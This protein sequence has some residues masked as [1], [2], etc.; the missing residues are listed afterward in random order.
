MDTI[1]PSPFAWAEFDADGGL[2]DAGAAAA[3]EAML[4]AAGIAD[5]VVLSHGW[6]NSKADAMT[7]YRTLWGNV[8]SALQRKN[9]VHIAV[10][11]VVWPSKAFSTDFDDAAAVASAAG[12]TL[13]VGDGGGSGDLDDARFEAAIRGV[14]ELFGPDS[15]PIVAAARAAAQGID[16]NTAS[17]FFE[18]AS[19]AVTPLPGDPELQQNATMFTPDARGVSPEAALGRL[20]PP[21][22]MSAAPGLGHASG[23]VDTLGAIFS[24][25]RAAVARAL[26]VLTYYEMKTR[27]GIVGAALGGRVLPGLHVSAGKSLHLVGHSFGARLVTAAAS[28]L[29]AHAPFAFSSLTLLQGA[30]SHN[31]LSAQASGA[32]ANVIGRPSGPIAITH[33][34]NDHACTYWYALASRLS[35]DSTQGFGDAD[36]IFGAMGANGAQKLPPGAIVHDTTGQTFAPHRGKVNG[37]LADGYVVEVAGVTDAH[38]NVANPTCGKLVAAVLEA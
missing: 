38:N 2:K 26:N 34:H 29:P 11:G 12:Q 16:F 28:A 10:V 17:A 18:A 8:V 9:P 23:L 3:I 22:A 7:L 35:N 20:I 27:A 4:N 14:E 32:F 1:G 31:G 33:T 25:P 36:D 19:A 13:S 15:A 30:F 21:P 6:N 5:F 37:F 24:G